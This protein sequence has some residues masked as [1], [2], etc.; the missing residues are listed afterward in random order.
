MATFRRDMGFMEDWKD[1][2]RVLLG[3]ELTMLQTLP[4][5]D[6]YPI[7]VACKE[8]GIYTVNWVI[9]GGK[10]WRPETPR[11]RNV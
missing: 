2:H 4:V 5:G 3:I 1:K 10:G 9:S 8:V 11:G 7:Q 6:N